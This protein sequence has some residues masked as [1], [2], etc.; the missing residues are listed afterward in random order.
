M[1]EVC[2]NRPTWIVFI[3]DKSMLVQQRPVN[4]HYDGVAYRAS[5]EEGV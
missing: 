4:D 1:R 3:F 2:V 5:L